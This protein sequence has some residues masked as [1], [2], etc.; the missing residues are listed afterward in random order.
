MAAPCKIKK[1]RFKNKL[2]SLDSSTISLRRPLFAWAKFRR[3]KVT[4]KRHGAAKTL[5]Q[6]VE[7]GL[8]Q[9]RIWDKALAR[10]QAYRGS[11]HG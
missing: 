10:F 6:G 1:F 4:V 11:Q 3:T 9:R 7:K 5:R 2:L 8:R